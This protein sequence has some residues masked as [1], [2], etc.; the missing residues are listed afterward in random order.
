[1]DLVAE[2]LDVA[3]HANEVALEL[4]DLVGGFLARREQGHR[5]LDALGVGGV[6]HGGVDLGA[7][8]EGIGGPGHGEGGDLAS[9]AVLMWGVSYRLDRAAGGLG[10]TGW[11]RGSQTY[12]DDAPGLDCGV[13]GLESVYVGG[14]LG[15][16]S[17]GG[18]LLEEGAEIL[19]LLVGVGWVPLG[20]AGVALEPVR[21]EHLVLGMVIAS[22]EDVGAL[23][24]LVKVPEDVVDVN[25]SLCG[26]GRTGYVLDKLPSASCYEV[27]MMGLSYRF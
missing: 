27:S 5:D 22:C 20:R 18:E 12:A 14:D 1:M 16:D 7:R 23:D 17:G 13:L 19:L 9:P 6:D 11:H 25:D 26:L 3:G 4:L 24:G 10:S 8:A 15:G 21:D 2:R